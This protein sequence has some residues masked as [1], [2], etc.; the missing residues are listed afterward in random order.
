MT[1][2]MKAFSNL[3]IKRKL[4][5]LA[6]FSSGMALLVACTMFLIFDVIMCREEMIKSLRM[7]AA[8]VG[9]NSLAALSFNEENDARQT[10]TSLR[11]DKHVVDACIFR[12][13]G[14]V[15]A[16]YGRDGAE[17]VVPA[18]APAVGYKFANQHLEVAEM[19][20]LDN[21]PI[22]TVYVRSDLGELHDRITRYAITLLGVFCAAAG[23]ALFLASRLQRFIAGPIQHLADTAQVVSTQ[24]NYSV[25]AVKES[26]DE[27]GQLIDVFN[28]MLTQIQIRDAGLKSHQDHLEEQVTQRTEQLQ[29]MNTE[30]T[31]AKD[32]A[33]AASRAKSNFLANMSHEIRTP[34]TAIVGYSDLMLEPEQTLSDRQDCLQIIRRNGRHLMALINDILDIS[35]IEAEKMTVERIPC[36]LPNLVIDVA[37]LM[38]PKT[39]DKGLDFTVNF[40]GSI[41]QTIL[42]DALRLKQI[43][44]NLLG[45][46]IKFTHK[47][48]IELRVGCKPKEGGSEIHFHLSDTGIGMT[49][50]QVQ[51][52]F[53]PFNQAD[54][55]MTRKYGG[56]GL[57]L[58]ISKRLAK[59]LGGDITIQTLHNVGSTFSVVI[60]G[61]S[62]DGVMM[63]TDV[64]EA[65][66]AVVPAPREEAIRLQG[67]ILL[68]E[69]GLD[70]QR[71]ISLHLRKAGAE[72]T[73]ADNGRIAVDLTRSQT[74][75][76]II[77]DMQM[78]ELDGYGAASEL[79]RRG[80]TLPIIALTAHAMAEDRARC[81]GAGCTDYLTKPIDKQQLLMTI[82]GHLREA[83]KMNGGTDATATA[84]ATASADAPIE[85]T[86]TPAA[87]APPVAATAPAAG[88]NVI[89]SDY[90]N[91]PDMREVIDEFVARLPVQVAGI[92]RMLD[93][94][95]L[96]E[97]R[98][99][100]HQM[101][102]AGGG[103]GFA[104][105]TTFAAKAEQAVKD[106][107]SLEKIAGQVEELVQLVRRVQGYDAKSE[108]L[109]KA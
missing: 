4:I 97:L 106:G 32:R 62:L 20:M 87:A 56:T 52:L 107:G 19:V 16:T 81:I 88:G 15:F 10:L 9:Q 38:R 3:S 22:G 103:Y 25:R 51:R 29:K 89:A 53:Q 23:L 64:T 47:G 33:E 28:E 17:A 101:K 79:R 93:E 71:L 92:K 96:D 48:R 26:S 5:V 18:A 77:M 70:N 73:I 65:I 108:Q 36:D 98:R 49:P 60:E 30:L 24:R 14:K 90:A 105:I 63:R 58:T 35:K 104:Q 67:R 82:N 54:D 46:A 40:E 21:N 99:A 78:P 84:V 12:T 2:S 7:H 76:L 61:G 45:N 55:S 11:V 59:L 44:V 86:V 83:K 95:N 31:G 75:D 109:Q 94:R 102:G 68:A 41:P 69:D 1:R 57:G 80:F 13:D 91:D 37:S 85:P 43:L 8:I 100:V 42:T 27:L 39:V 74:F 66:L 72:V 34:M 50:E 6:M